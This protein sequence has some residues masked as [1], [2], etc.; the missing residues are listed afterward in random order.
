M[1]IYDES[2]DITE[3][4]IKLESTT[5]KSFV[6][7]YLPNEGNVS[8]HTDARPP[9]HITHKLLPKGVAFIIFVR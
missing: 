3:M 1:V 8:V 4:L 2:W 9:D 7:Y 5:Q 6:T